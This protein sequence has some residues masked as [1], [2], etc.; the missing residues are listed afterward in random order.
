MGDIEPAAQQLAIARRSEDGGKVFNVWFPESQ[1]FSDDLKIE[2]KN[3]ST[4]KIF[5]TKDTGFHI[6]LIGGRGRDADKTGVEIWN[7]KENGENK[8]VR[9][10]LKG[11][12]QYESINT[13][14]E[15]LVICEY[16][17]S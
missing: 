4:A 17:C 8:M 9:H 3:F 16:V 15:F 10:L 12:K 7:M 6:F 11:E 13:N 2:L 14:G 1:E 5:F